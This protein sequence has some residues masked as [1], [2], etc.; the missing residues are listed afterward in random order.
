[1][2]DELQESR[3]SWSAPVAAWEGLG[4]KA[5]RL[6]L[7]THEAQTLA[8]ALRWTLGAY[9][10]ELVF[11]AAEAQNPAPPTAAFSERLWR[12]ELIGD[13]VNG[14]LRELVSEVS[15]RL[16]AHRRV[17]ATARASAGDLKAQV[18]DYERRLVA[19][20][21]EVSGGS[22]KLAAAALGILPSTLNEKM[23]RLGLRMGSSRGPTATSRR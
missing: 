8:R 10:R 20:A 11:F 21:L 2:Q 12:V 19:S 23:K 14:L 1:M 13:Q 5:R 22:Q 3:E 18:E 17:F 7:I 6:M 15:R 9:E 4:E 16:E